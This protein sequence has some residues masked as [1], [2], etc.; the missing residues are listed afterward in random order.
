[1]KYEVVIG[2]R[3]GELTVNGASFRY[4]RQGAEAIE[5]EFSLRT[6]QPGKYSVLIEGRSYAVTLDAEN[7]LLV[8]G[9]TLAIEV[10]DPRETRGR[11]SAGEGHGRQSIA[12]PMPGKVVRVLVAPGDEVAAGQGLIVVEA[13]KMQ[14]EMKSPAAGRVVELRTQANATVAAGEVLVIIE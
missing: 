10:F 14:N 6:L 7:E 11:R 12:A 1:M 13:M 3:S 8:N 2:G 4:R 9:R 5:R